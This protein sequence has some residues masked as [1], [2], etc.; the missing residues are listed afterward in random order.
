MNQ[1][2]LTDIEMFECELCLHTSHLVLVGLQVMSV[3]IL[4][5][6]W[7]PLSMHD[8][9]QRQGLWQHGQCQQ[10]QY[11]N[12]LQQ[13]VHQQCQLCQLLCLLHQQCHPLMTMAMLWM[14]AS[15]DVDVHMCAHCPDQG[16]ANA[17]STFV[18]N[19][20]AHLLQSAHN[21][22][23]FVY[24]GS[25]RGSNPVCVSSISVPGTFYD[26][27]ID[28]EHVLTNTFIHDSFNV[29]Q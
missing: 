14:I 27:D 17:W 3:K 26:I 11:Q 13:P 29:N 10:H 2:T 6:M 8:A 18:P 16:S 25:T 24:C 7:L 21:M 28:F 22:D 4:F 12:L 5:R 19:W 9:M 1:L 20:T 15:L 23:S